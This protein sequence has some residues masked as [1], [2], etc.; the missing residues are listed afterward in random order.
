MSLARFARMPAT[1]ARRFVRFSSQTM[2]PRAAAV[3]H[4]R[5]LVISSAAF[6][7]WAV[8][9]SW[10]CHPPPRCCNNSWHPPSLQVEELNI[11]RSNAQELIAKVPPIIVDANVAMCDGG[12]A[13]CPLLFT[14]ITC[15][16]RGE[17]HFHAAGGGATG[18]PIEFIQLNKREGDVPATCKY[19]GLRY[20]RKPHHH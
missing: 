8:F 14:R 10:R 11:H 17:R 7:L 1:V 5:A 20:Q 4:A 19:C 16:P 15:N 6:P 13:C 2:I 12:M 18:H 3:S 9:Q